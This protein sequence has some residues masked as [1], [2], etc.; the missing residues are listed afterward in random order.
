MKKITGTSLPLWSYFAAA[1]ALLVSAS[2]A[3]ASNQTW[4]A[5]GNGDWNTGGSWGGTP[6]PG[7]SAT[8]G[9][10]TDT[11]T[12]GTVSTATHTVSDSVTNRS[13]GQILFNGS[14][15]AG[16]SYVIGSSSNTIYFNDLNVVSGTTANISITAGNNNETIASNLMI[17]GAGN[18]VAGNDLRLQTFGGY[19]GTLTVS[20]NIAASTGTPGSISGLRIVTSGSTTTHPETI[21]AMSSSSPATSPTARVRSECRAHATAFFSSA[22][23]TPTA[24]VSS[25]APT[26]TMAIRPTPSPKLA[27]TVLARQATSPAARSAPASSPSQAALSARTARPPVPS[28]TTSRPLVRRSTPASVP[29]P[30]AP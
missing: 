27:S 21:P 24:A 9:A 11:A 6:V 8:T 18:S 3:Q 5:T 15:G 13:L 10:N 20:G 22:A 2:P 19:T 26:A 1:L 28:T 12:F 25:S 30:R 23:S 17:T 14:T 29:D 7:I 4:A 16:G